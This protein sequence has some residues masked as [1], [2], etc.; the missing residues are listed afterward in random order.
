LG[1]THD[2][3]CSSFWLKNMAERKVLELL[4]LDEGLVVKILSLLDLLQVGPVALSC[5]RLRELLFSHR[6]PLVTSLDLSTYQYRLRMTDA[7]LINLLKHCTNLASLDITYCFRLTSKSLIEIRS[8][9]LSLERLAMGWNRKVD[10]STLSQL[11][12]GLTVSSAASTSLFKSATRTGFPKLTHLDLRGCW[13]LQ[14]TDLEAILKYCPALTHANFDY[15]SFTE[16]AVKQYVAK[17]Q[18]TLQEISL[19]WTATEERPPGST[20]PPWFDS[21]DFPKYLKVFTESRPP[22]VLEMSDDSYEEQLQSMTERA[23]GEGKHILLHLGMKANFPN[24]VVDTFTVRLH[25]F[26]TTNKELVYLMDQWYVYWILDEA[27]IR[28]RTHVIKVPAGGIAE[29]PSLFVLNQDGEVMV[30]KGTGDLEENCPSGC[31]YNPQKLFHF[32]RKWHPGAVLPPKQ[33]W[34]DLTEMVSN[35]PINPMYSLPGPL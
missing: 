19:W 6:F 25:N 5:R 35:V 22:T 18:D 21:I 23:Q 29:Y 7:A 27:L 13:N 28:D 31:T 12:V 10:S 24:G 17:M 11:I 32:L 20:L 2:V 16:K 14:D 4:D 30:G 33:K 9:A 34:P 26:L 1:R 8:K 15:C 3:I